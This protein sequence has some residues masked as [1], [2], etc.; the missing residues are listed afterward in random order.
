M[1]ILR[2]SRI[3]DDIIDPEM[4]DMD[5]IVVV[6]LTLQKDK[7]IAALG[8]LAKKLMASVLRPHSLFTTT[9]SSTITSY[10]YPAPKSLPVDRTPSIEMM[11]PFSVVSDDVTTRS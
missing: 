9:A 7:I 1:G 5:L 8:R 10:L 2:Q 4:K 11:E 6:T 3:E